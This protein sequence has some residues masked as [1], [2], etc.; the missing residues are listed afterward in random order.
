[1]SSIRV[2]RTLHHAAKI[3]HD[4]LKV[5]TEEVPAELCPEH[6]L[7]LVLQVH[8]RVWMEKPLAT[9]KMQPH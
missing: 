2:A 6:L 3:K 7:L 5:R 8:S 1:M 4:A 9:L